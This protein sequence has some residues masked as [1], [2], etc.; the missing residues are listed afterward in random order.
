LQEQPWAI[1]TI[2]YTGHCPLTL[3]TNLDEIG[4]VEMLISVG[5]DVNQ[6]TP[7]GESALILAASIGNPESV[8]LLLNAK[9]RVDWADIDGSTALHLASKSQCVES[10][11]LL[12]AAGA[13]ANHR[14]IFGVTPLH[15][16]ATR[17]TNNHD[18]TKRIIDLLVLAGA[19]LDERDIH[20]STT[21]MLS[22]F[23]DNIS[24]MA[25]LLDRGC[26]LSLS[27]SDNENILHLAA[28]H[29]SLKMLEYLGGLGLYDINPFQK[30]FR[31]RTPRYL[32]LRAYNQKIFIAR[33]PS[34]AELC[35][36]FNLC[37]G[38][39]DRSFQHDIDNIEQ[40]VAALRDRDVATARKHLGSLLKKEERWK[41]EDLICWYR[42]IDKRIQNLEWDLATEDLGEYLTELK[43]ELGTPVYDIP[44]RYGCTF[45]DSQ[46]W[47]TTTPESEISGSEI[48]V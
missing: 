18:D 1:N 33:V 4:C 38:I 46:T 24:A 27:D 3:A 6:R 16:L 36:F 23:Y 22:L 45:L 40:V 34:T 2:D 13:S 31:G 15:R 39:Q 19:N 30:N 11:G 26:S 21:A 37:Q 41:C 25:C 7:R 14:D 47:E 48:L 8:R 10:V 28:R 12:L 5:V 17:T 32:I 44:S 29:S 20:G 43:E 42:A 35:A 9:C